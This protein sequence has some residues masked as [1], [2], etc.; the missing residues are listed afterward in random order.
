[1][2]QP[3]Y[4]YSDDGGVTW[5][6]NVPLAADAFNPLL[7]WPQQ[8]KIG[9]YSGIVSDRVGAD[10]IFAATY[11]NEQDVYY[12]R[13]GDRD[14]NDNGVGDADDI[15][16]GFDTDLDS[17]GIPDHCE[18]DADGDGAVD[19]IDNC[20]FVANRDQI[21]SDGNGIGDACES[22]FSD[23]FESGDTSAWTATVP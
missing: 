20:P 18:S 9:D 12:V 4:S 16:S 19:A 13:I 15:S 5:S 6:A 1:M 10:A 14:C 2:S 17:D 7:G 21:D 23:G 22:L 3:Y 8:N 11:N